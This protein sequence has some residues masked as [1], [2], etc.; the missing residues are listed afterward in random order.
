MPCCHSVPD[1][2]NNNKKE[3]EKKED[4][5]KSHYLTKKKKDYVKKAIHEL[6]DE[7]KVKTLGEKALSYS[8]FKQ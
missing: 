3:K 6:H 7:D 2:N 1:N 5:S 8:M 4:M